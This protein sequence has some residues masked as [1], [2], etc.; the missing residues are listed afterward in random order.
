MLPLIPLAIQIA[1]SIA[2]WLFGDDSGKVVQQVASVVTETTGVAEP[3]TPDGIAAVEAVL[4]GSP[5][6]A[7]QIQVQLAKIAADRETEAG[8]SMEAARK[9]EFDALLARFAD[10][11][12]ARRQ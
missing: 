5:E 4:Q 9:A 2:K 10:T 8:R 1:P 6:L 11:D 3:H 7:L 12:S